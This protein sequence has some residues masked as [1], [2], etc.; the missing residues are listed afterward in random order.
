VAYNAKVFLAGP[1]RMGKSTLAMRL[2][3]SAPAPRMIWDPADSSTTM[4]PGAVTFSDPRKATNRKGESWREAATARFVPRNPNDLAAYGAVAAWTVAEG[5][6]GRPRI[7]LN[8]EG[9][10]TAP[11]RRVHPDV[12]SLY[13]RGGK[14]QCGVLTNHVR[15]HQVE[16]N[17]LAQAEHLAVVGLLTNR[18]D[19]AIC[20]DY[21][22]IEPAELKAL[23]AE[24]HTLW[25]GHS[26]GRPFL[27]FDRDRQT[28]LICPPLRLRR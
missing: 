11:V 25:D 17:A 22:G 2:L 21:A 8:D 9:A 12:Q 6:R 15:V 4:V 20:A 13:L 10:I 1:T 28:V 16:P 14:L 27:W 3:L 24:A 5:E 18:A 7:T 23:M 19:V 26:P